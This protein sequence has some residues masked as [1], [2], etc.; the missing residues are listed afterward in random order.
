VNRALRAAA[1]GVL[2]IAPVT[3]SA[4]SSGQVNQTS[5]QNRDKVGA[6]ARV[7]DITL[8][9]MEIAFPRGGRYPRGSDAVLNGAV[10]NSGGADDTLVSI[11]GDG[12]TGVDVT[13]TGAQATFPTGGPAAATTGTG[14]PATGTGAGA[15]TGA[16]TD[17]SGAAATGTGATATTGAATT[18]S[19]PLPTE[20]PSSS[21]G[22]KIPANSVAFL[23]QNVPH[24]TLTG[25]T[26]PLNAAQSLRLTFTFQRAGTVTV[27]VIVASPTSP[28]PNNSTFN[29]EVPTQAN[30]PN[31]QVGGANPSAA[32][33]NG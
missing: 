8:R 20:A 11:T 6:T 2:L 16:A 22:I 18:T 10:V 24:V 19:E 31:N 3:L 29:F 33:G 15:T 27:D 14:S 12:I 23:G 9:E 32:N 25:L 1:I 5:S 17:T 21:V 13:G 30:E 7:G 26:S 28:V 4:C